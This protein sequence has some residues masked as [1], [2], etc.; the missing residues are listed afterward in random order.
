MINI[1]IVTSSKLYVRKHGMYDFKATLK[2]NKI[3]YQN[4]RYNGNKYADYSLNYNNT[5]NVKYYVYDWSGTCQDH[6]NLTVLP[7]SAFCHKA[8]YFWN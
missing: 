1:N 8:N 4:G 6:Q 3:Y 5:I 2:D 7:T